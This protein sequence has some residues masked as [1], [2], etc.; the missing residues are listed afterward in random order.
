MEHRVLKRMYST[1]EPSILWPA[2]MEAWRRCRFQMWAGGHLYIEGHGNYNEIVIFPPV[3]GPQLLGQDQG[4]E[5]L[6]A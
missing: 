4:P 3:H 6:V 2:R 1:W 5:F